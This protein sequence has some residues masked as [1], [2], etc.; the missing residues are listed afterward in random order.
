VQVGLGRERA[1]ISARNVVFKEL[2]YLGSSAGTREDCAQV[3]RLIADG[4]ASSILTE[5]TFDEI[6]E[7]AQ[8]LQRGGV[9]G[10]LVA[11]LD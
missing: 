8:R 9:V 5:I 4:K 3:M 7:A 11:I 1:D 6:G 10:R 2:T